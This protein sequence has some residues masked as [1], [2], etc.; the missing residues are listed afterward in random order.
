MGVAPLTTPRPVEPEDC[1]DPE[2]VDTNYNHSYYKHYLVHSIPQD[3]QIPVDVVDYVVQYIEDGYN[4]GD[5]IEAQD[6]GSKWY[7]STVLEVKMGKIFVHY[8]NWPSKWD[9]WIDI[10]SE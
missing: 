8:E 5:Q 10:G 3:L 4:V 9:E 7:L 6:K 1:K 2:F